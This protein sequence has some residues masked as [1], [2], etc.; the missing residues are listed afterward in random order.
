M[1]SDTRKKTIKER[2]NPLFNV[3]FAYAHYD[4]EI[5]YCQGLNLIVSFLL[6]TTIYKSDNFL[7]DRNLCVKCNV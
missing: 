4:T 3:L 5:E 7:D 1:F 2:R 6:K